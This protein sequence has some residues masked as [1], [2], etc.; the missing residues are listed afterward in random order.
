MILTLSLG[1]TSTKFGIFRD[2]EPLLTHSI[3]YSP[4][5]LAPYPDAFAQLPRRRDDL[6]AALHAADFAL[7]F[8]AIIARG[9]LTHPIP[10]GIYAVN[11]AMLRDTRTAM[12]QHVC[13]LGCHLAAELAAHQPHCHA[14]IADPEV[15]DEMPPEARLS[16]SPL[17]ERVCIWHA[18]NQ[19][20]IARKYA[21]AHGTR[22]EDLNLIIAHLGGGI[23]IGA[24]EHGRT[25]DVNN[26]LD[27][28]GPFSPERAGTLPSADLIRLCFSGRFSERELLARI[29]GQAG[30]NAHLGTTDVREV[31]NRIA[32]GDDHARLVLDAMTYQVAKA[33]AAQGAV[34]CGRVDAI[35][36]TGGVA[37]AERVVEGIR[38]R[39]EYLAPIHV[40]PGENELESLA[41]NAQAALMGARPVLEYA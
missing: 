25:I 8:R 37:R 24:H 16:G 19:R 11:D 26:G 39:V 2:G 12:R 18:L 23:T 6:L 32:A 3:S 14:L 22:Y 7:N 15:A 33:I 41:E 27:G 13:N 5:D 38:R 31:L 21:A 34:L 35:L 17:M 30:L 10:A 9:G 36:I 40:F 29:V 4:A 20:A 1:S 28:E